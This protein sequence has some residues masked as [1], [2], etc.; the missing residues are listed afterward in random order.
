MK[1]VS[2]SERMKENGKTEE[3]AR[4]DKTGNVRRECPPAIQ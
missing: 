4:C 2:V 1:H 3:I